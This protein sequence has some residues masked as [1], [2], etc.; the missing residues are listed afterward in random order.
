MPNDRTEAL[1]NQQII[2]SNI[3][4][5][6]IVASL[7]QDFNLS[8]IE[9]TLALVYNSGASPVILLSKS[10][11]CDNTEQKLNS[12]TEIA[13]GVPIIDFSNV[14]GNG[15]DEIKKFI[16]PQKTYCLLGSSGVGKTSLMNILCNK[17]EKTAEIRESDDR[18]R[19]ATTARNLYFLENGAM[20]IDTPGIREV[21]I[22]EFGDNTENFSDIEELAI[23]CK[24]TNCTHTN[25]PGCTIT[26]ALVDGTLNKRRFQN[27]IKLKTEAQFQA[28]KEVA[29]K[30]KKDK[31]K[32]IAKLNK[33]MKK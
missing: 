30:N 18:G 29:L 24:F 9:R 16:Q 3:D 14:T 13:F 2:A 17:N 25:E 10:D 33:Q 6:F 28:D 19:H 23:H 21:G 31:F 22:I 4:T 7:N 11:L 15:I 27:W 5:V 8:R 12:V 26:S 20:V 1:G 32:K